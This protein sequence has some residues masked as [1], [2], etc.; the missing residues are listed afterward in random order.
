MIKITA[1]DLVEFKKQ[2]RRDIAKVIPDKTGFSTIGI[3]E[4][5]GMHEDSEK[6]VAE[7]AA[8]NHYGTEIIPARRFLDVGVESG[9]EIYIREIKRTVDN[10]GDINQALELVSELAVGEVQM[11]ITNLRKPPNSEATIA[12]K[13]SSNP[14]I[15][16]GQMRQSITKEMHTTKVEEG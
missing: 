9:S 4:G 5:A 1:P 15:D 8:E 6:T 13:G 16:T 3:H 10:G 14:L 11:Y 12:R 2:L 7:I